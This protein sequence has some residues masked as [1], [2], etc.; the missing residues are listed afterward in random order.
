MAKRPDNRPISKQSEERPGKMPDDDGLSIPV[1]LL[2]K[3]GKLT[4]LQV[5]RLN[6]PNR[7]WIMPSASR[8]EPESPSINTV[9]SSL[10][11][12]VN[13]KP[14]GK[15]GT[16]HN[17][18]CLGEGGFEDWFD[19]SIHRIMGSIADPSVTMIS[20]EEIY[21]TPT[22]AR[23]TGKRSLA[24]SPPPAPTGRKTAR[25]L[26]SG[27]GE[28]EEAD[29]KATRKA[30]KARVGAIPPP[31]KGRVVGRGA[32]IKPAAGKKP[33][34]V[35]TGRGGH[36][37]GQTIV[38]HGCTVNGGKEVFGSVYK[39]FES[40]RLDISKHVKFRALLKGAKGGEATY[41]QGGK[42]FVFR[43]AELKK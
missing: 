10:P 14:V 25:S 7:E 42:K 39:A 34:G 4:D 12:E 20:V 3:D 6:Q 15:P 29:I 38:R 31:V 2:R 30:E 17:F 32:V 9:S 5:R 24:K 19:P 41:E 8:V 21:R 11:V 33:S 43:L 22:A 23:A 27:I 28:L 1:F 18:D 13:Y 37:A 16:V 35:G 36:N 26:T 40:L